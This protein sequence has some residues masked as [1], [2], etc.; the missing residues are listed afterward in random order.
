MDELN[1]KMTATTTQND[2][3]KELKRSFL[4]PP[5]FIEYII[6]TQFEKIKEI[7]LIRVVG[8]EELDV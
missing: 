3:K 8:E 5:D 2:L 6:D 4:E 1:F 7:E